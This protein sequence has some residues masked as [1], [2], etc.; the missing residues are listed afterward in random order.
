[1][2]ILCT[3]LGVQTLAKW[4]MIFPE[5]DELR[6]V[7]YYAQDFAAMYIDINSKKTTCFRKYI[8]LCNHFRP[9]IRQMYIC[10]TLGVILVSLLI[11]VFTNT[12]ILAIGIVLPI[13]DY[14]SDLGYLINSALYAIIG[15]TGSYG[16]FTSDCLYLIAMAIAYGQVDAIA[17]ACDDLVEYLE[18]NGP[19]DIPEIDTLISNIVKIHLSH[20]RYM[21]HLKK[22]FSLHSATMVSISMIC[23]AITLF[24]VIKA[25]W[26][27]GILMIGIFIW[28][29]FTIC[30]FGGIYMIK[31]DKLQTVLYNTKWYLLPWPK[32]KMLLY[33]IQ[34][35]QNTPE[36]R[37][38]SIIPLNFRTFY[39]CMKTMYKLL[40]LLFNITN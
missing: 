12:K 21:N 28:Q 39:D 37:A 15:T 7:A 32:Q 40:M 4:N 36:P 22:I 1:M 20:K 10:A 3:L 17:A 26:S 33:I 31:L 5:V 13:L 8:D 18:I 23:Q 11:S 14:Q 6:K 24:I 25:Q 38:V 29:I 2:S 19:E 30:C 16:L 35:I 34:N 27:Y 9:Y